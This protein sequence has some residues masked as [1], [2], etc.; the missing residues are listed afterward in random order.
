MGGKAIYEDRLVQVFSDSILLKN[1]YLFS[2]GSKRIPFDRIRTITVE[3]PTLFTGK[4]R[5]QGSGDL[6]TWFPLDAERP[7]RDKVFLVTLLDK[8]TRIGFTVEHSDEVLRI[9]KEKGLIPSAT[10]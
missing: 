10:A 8:R 4:W 3:K 2:V 5:L 9:L 1:Y 6:R 7:K